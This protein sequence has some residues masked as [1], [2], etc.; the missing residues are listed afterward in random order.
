MEGKG[1][2]LIILDLVVKGKLKSRCAAFSNAF[3]LPFSS[4]PS[5]PKQLWKAD[6]L[7]C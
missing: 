4:Y 6:R 5:V 1:T 2:F 3:L 7:P